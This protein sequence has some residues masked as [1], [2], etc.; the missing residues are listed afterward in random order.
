MKELRRFFNFIDYFI[1]H[2]SSKKLIQASSFFMAFLLFQ[3]Y[4]RKWIYQSFL[5][6]LNQRLN[7]LLTQQYIILFKKIM[8]IQNNQMNPITL[9]NKQLRIF[10]KDQNSAHLSKI[11]DYMATKRATE[12][13]NH[14]IK[15]IILSGRHEILTQ[16]NLDIDNLM[17]TI[18]NMQDFISN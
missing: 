6:G 4:P 7:L 16:L 13:V 12:T 2:G 1:F 10:E 9:D 15:P 3:L 18:P 14:A 17:H 5:S 8:T 11:I